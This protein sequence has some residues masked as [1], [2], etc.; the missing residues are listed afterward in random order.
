MKLSLPLE[1]KLRCCS[2]SER[3]REIID[4]LVSED[5][6][7]VTHDEDPTTPSYNKHRQHNNR[8]ATIKVVTFRVPVTPTVVLISV[9]RSLF[10]ID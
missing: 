4:S 10:L 5:V 2:L 8:A 7:V 1:L 9:L 6:V 3:R